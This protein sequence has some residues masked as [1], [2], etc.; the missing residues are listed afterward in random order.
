MGE[1]AALEIMGWDG[2]ELSLERSYHNAA[3]IQRPLTILL[4][5]AMQRKGE[6]LQAQP[7]R[8]TPQPSNELEK[9]LMF[10]P[11]QTLHHTAEQT[12]GAPP[13]PGSAFTLFAPSWAHQE[14]LMTNGKDTLQCRD[15]RD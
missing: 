2:P 15:E 13:S 9:T 4:M 10:R 8:P 12:R 1:A 14:T 6:A 11:A 3:V 7:A 5:E